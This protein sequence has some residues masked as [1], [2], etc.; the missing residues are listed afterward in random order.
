VTGARKPRVLCLD[1]EPHVLESLRDTLRR[2]FEV[3]ITTNGFE[4][5]R[6]L[7]EQP[8]EVVVSD[9]RMPRLNGA[10]FLTLAREHAPETVRVMLTGHST[11]DDAA[12]AINSSIP[13][14]AS[15]RCAGTAR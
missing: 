4:A 12:A 11:L 9:M 13:S 10:R 14:T 7:T 1:D 3:V 5:L 15:P 8:C 2:R 6:L